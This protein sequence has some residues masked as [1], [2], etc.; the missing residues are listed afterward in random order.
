MIILITELSERTDKDT[1]S[2]FVS[3]GLRRV[4]LL[5]VFRK[6]V[7]KYCQIRRI[8]DPDSDIA[9]YQAMVQMDD[10]R[11]AQ[12]LIRQLHGK[13]LDGASVQARVYHHRSP[14]KDRR[15]RLS[16]SDNI[17]ILDR[18]VS[19]RRRSHL[20]IETLSG[21]AIQGGPPG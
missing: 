5:P 9:E 6:G 19:D 10:E 20:S 2:A 15:V 16:D 4:W 3:D 13:R 17:A 11:T 14:R 21:Q 1:L 7:M 18:R 12:A 8:R